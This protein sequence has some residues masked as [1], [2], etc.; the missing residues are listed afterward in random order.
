MAYENQEKCVECGISIPENCEL[1]ESCYHAEEKEALES[2]KE[3]YTIS[4]TR[5]GTGSLDLHVRAE[6]EEKAQEIALDEA[7][8]YNFSDDSSEY[9]LTDDLVDEQEIDK[10]FIFD[11]VMEA[12]EDRLIALE[13]AFNDYPVIAKRCLNKAPF[14]PSGD[15]EVD[16]ILG[17]IWGLVTNGIIEKC[18]ALGIVHFGAPVSENKV[19]PSVV[20][21]DLDE[22]YELV[23]VPE[24]AEQPTE[25]SP[26]QSDQEER[27]CQSVGELLHMGVDKETILRQVELQF[28]AHEEN[29]IE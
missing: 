9:K 23:I 3:E 15:Q 29:S 20:W 7:A 28:Q 2:F 12:L 14:E 21:M 16:R 18:V 27:M 5:I 11:K 24:Y 25:I 22:I 8:D 4:V 1:C 10:R 6:S 17:Y 13:D 19:R 26:E